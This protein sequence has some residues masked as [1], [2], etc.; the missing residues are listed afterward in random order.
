MID[1]GGRGRGSHRQPPRLGDEKIRAGEGDQPDDDQKYEAHAKRPPELDSRP[2]PL[3]PCSNS[4]CSEKWGMETG[5]IYHS[6]FLAQA[7]SCIYYF[8]PKRLLPG[9]RPKSFSGITAKT[10]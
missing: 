10:H 6:F 8:S 1:S 4:P 3:R 9:N 5:R 2:S 7:G